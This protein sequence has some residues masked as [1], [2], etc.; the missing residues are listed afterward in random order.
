MGH[1]DVVLEGAAWIAIAI[2]EDARRGIRRVDACHE[3]G[4]FFACDEVSVRVDVRIT[5]IVV[6]DP[7]VGSVTD[8]ARDRPDVAEPA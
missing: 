2:P 3:A 6:V 4:G 5:T 8:P 1:V 7:L